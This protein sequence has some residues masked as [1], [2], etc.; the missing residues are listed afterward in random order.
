M[1]IGIT[2]NVC[3][4]FVGS[5]LGII[6]GKRLP[7]NLKHAL[8]NI[9]GIAAISMGIVLILRQHTLSAVVLAVV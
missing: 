2:V 5:I 1:P 7:D 9:L 8:N 6:L 3:A 4:T